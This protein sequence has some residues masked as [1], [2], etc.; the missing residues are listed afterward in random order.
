MLCIE[1]NNKMELNNLFFLSGPHGSGKTTLSKILEENIKE[2]V[3]PELL[4]YTPKFYTGLDEENIDF[5][6][7]Q[8]LKHSQRAIEGYEYQ[9]HAKNNP[10]NIILGNR[11][12]YDVFCYDEAYFK[13]GWINE[14]E[15]VKLNVLAG[16]VY[17]Q[18]D[19]PI[20]I[21]LNPGFET[22][23]RH[24]EK[25]WETKKKKF[26]EDDMD[27]LR[28]VCDS[29]ESYKNHEN[30]LYIDHEIETEDLIDI[31]NF[32][33]DKSGIFENKLVFV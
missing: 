33:Y 23:K 12:K 17:N 32:I 24:L 8:I 30:I 25:R 21:I 31:T 22:C 3:V 29:Y 9:E 5:F 14:L 13:R 16:V 18:L 1:K 15:N 6:N 26:L 10:H 2:L 4:T 11:C 19:N 28:C 7:R 27:Y 20:T